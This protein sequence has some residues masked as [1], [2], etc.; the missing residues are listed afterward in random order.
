MRAMNSGV[1]IGGIEE[2]ALSGTAEPTTGT[3]WLSL[4]GGELK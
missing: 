1:L 4:K 2:G 3:L